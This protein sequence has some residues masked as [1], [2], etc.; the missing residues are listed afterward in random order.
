MLK[1]REDKKLKID[2]VKAYFDTHFVEK[3]WTCKKG[4]FKAVKVESLTGEVSNFNALSNDF[5][6][7]SIIMVRGKK[8][9]GYELALKLVLWGQGARAGTEAT[10]EIEELCDDGSDPNCGI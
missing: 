9:I 4:E 2:T 6:K 7:T 10:F 8:R 1:N 3:G 5:M